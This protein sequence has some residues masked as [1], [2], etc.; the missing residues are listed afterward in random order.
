[1]KAVHTLYPGSDEERKWSIAD[2]DKL[3]GE[4]SRIDIISLSNLGEYYR[5]FLTITTYLRSKNCLSEAEQS[6]AFVQGLPPTLWS[7]ISQRLQLKLPD[8]FPDDPYPLKS[9]HEA[10]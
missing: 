8:H 1:M 3:I 4:R 6:H 9:I 10:A 7:V 5:Q 2:M